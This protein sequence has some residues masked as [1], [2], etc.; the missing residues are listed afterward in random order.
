MKSLDALYGEGMI[1]HACKI[2]Y[3]HVPAMPVHGYTRPAE[4][5]S[6]RMFIQ[7]SKSRSIVI[8]IVGLFLGKGGKA[9]L[10]Y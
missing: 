2:S 1:F 3:V 6:R 8:N 10:P 7:Y 9:R 5:P 4:P